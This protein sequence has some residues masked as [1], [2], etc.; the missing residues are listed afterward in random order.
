MK[1]PKKSHYS[2][3]A[4]QKEYKW[5]KYTLYIPHFKNDRFIE[6]D[7]WSKLKRIYTS[8]T[9]T[10]WFKE[11]TRQDRITREK[12]FNKQLEKWHEEHPNTISGNDA[13]IHFPLSKQLKIFFENSKKK[14]KGNS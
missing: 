9:L 11:E 1:L 10:F 5:Y 13:I 6:N 2:P 12:R 3:W 14:F 8:L 4:G 7:F